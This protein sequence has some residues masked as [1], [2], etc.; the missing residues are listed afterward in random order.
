MK[1]FYSENYLAAA[2]EVF[3]SLIYNLEFEQKI[4]RQRLIETD[5]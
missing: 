3:K 2:F 5:P 1:K 4:E